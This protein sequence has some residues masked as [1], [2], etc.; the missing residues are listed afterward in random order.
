MT[1]LLKEKPD[2]VID[3]MLKW[4]ETEGRKLEG[5][6]EEEYDNSHLP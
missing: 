6:K 5:G 3:F 4:C 1:A 2:K